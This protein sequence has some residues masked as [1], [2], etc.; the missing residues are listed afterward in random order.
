MTAG[1]RRRR[2]GPKRARVLWVE[3]SAHFENT[4]LAAPVILSDQFELV[5]ALDATDG[6][7]HLRRSVFDAVVVDIRLPP[8]D[9]QWWVNFYMDLFKKNRP[10]RLGLKLLEIVLIG[11]K[12]FENANFAAVLRDPRRY[13]V[14]SVENRSDLMADLQRL[15][16][17]VY[18]DKGAGDD[19]EVLLQTI[20]DILTQCS[21]AG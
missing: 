9:D 13:G 21:G 3:D 1:R 17:G 20:N 4:M 15:R 18:R 19:P 5:V 14:L 8:G 16:V 7:R 12:N 11:D 2:G 10:P 6:I